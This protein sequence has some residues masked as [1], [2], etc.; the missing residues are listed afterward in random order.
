MSIEEARGAV[1]LWLST[2][3]SEEERHIRRIK[4][5]DNLNII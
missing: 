2:N 4:K 1:A 5:I 3:F